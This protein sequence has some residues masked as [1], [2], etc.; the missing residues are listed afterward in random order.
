MQIVSY[1]ELRKNLANSLDKVVADRSPLI[2][3]RQNAE[4]AVLIS[5][6]DFNAYEETAYLLSSPKN[7]ERLRHSLAQ[8]K[9]GE[10]TQ[11]AL[12]EVE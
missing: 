12:I 6:K 10:V 3:T 9:A 7:A 2:I 4:A 11:Q 1:T 8:V 5:L